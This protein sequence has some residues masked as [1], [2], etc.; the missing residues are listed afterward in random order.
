MY[1]L[2]QPFVI[3]VSRAGMTVGELLA[4]QEEDT[5]VTSTKLVQI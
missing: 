3:P 4:W 2:S 5:G 1:S